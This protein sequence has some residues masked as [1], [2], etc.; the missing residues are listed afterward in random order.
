M[1]SDM[2]EQLLSERAQA[3]YAKKLEQLMQIER[4]LKQYG[5]WR[6]RLVI[7]SLI[8]DE[9]LFVFVDSVCC[10][11]C[12]VSPVTLLH[13]TAFCL[14]W[15]FHLHTPTVIHMKHIYYMLSWLVMY[16]T[17]QIKKVWKYV[18]VNNIN[19]YISL[20]WETFFS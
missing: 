9:F 1:K 14:W 17:K 12:V 15:W 13:S 20:L 19:M 18:R 11:F 7:R 6:I 10:N 8:F 16:Q 2:K 5:I 4:M 3:K